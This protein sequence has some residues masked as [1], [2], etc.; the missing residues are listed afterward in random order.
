MTCRLVKPHLGSVVVGSESRK[1][2]E[3]WQLVATVLVLLH[4]HFLM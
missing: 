4:T 1:V 2:V 3:N